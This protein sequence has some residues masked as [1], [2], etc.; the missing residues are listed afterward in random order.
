MSVRAIERRLKDTIK[1]QLVT[2]TSGSGGFTYGAEQTI[3]KCRIEDSF[4]E[5][6]KNKKGDEVKSKTHIVTFELYVKENSKITE[7]NGVALTKP[8][9]VKAD[10]KTPF[11][12]YDGYLYEFWI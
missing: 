8:L 4:E 3:S 9:I 7:I 6:I 11:I 1:V 5:T 12:R 10:R 2:G